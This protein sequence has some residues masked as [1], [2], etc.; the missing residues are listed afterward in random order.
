MQYIS[1]PGEGFNMK[2]STLTFAILVVLHMELM[3]ENLFN[4]W[5][6]KPSPVPTLH[7]NTERL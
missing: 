2:T 6:I 3:R 4:I 5:R 1:L 7:Y